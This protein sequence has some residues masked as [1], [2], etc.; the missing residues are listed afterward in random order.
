VQGHGRQGHRGIGEPGDVGPVA[1]EPAPD[2]GSA[3]HGD[4]AVRAVSAV[5]AGQAGTLASDRDGAR[6]RRAPPRQDGPGGDGGRPGRDGELQGGRGFGAGDHGPGLPVGPVEGPPP[7][8][9]HHQTVAYLD[10]YLG[11]CSAEDLGGHQAV[12]G[13]RAVGDED[14]RVGVLPG[15]G[16]EQRVGGLGGLAFPG[17]VDPGDHSQAG[18]LAVAGQAH[19]HQG[20]RWVEPQQV[21]HRRQHV[22]G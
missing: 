17:Q 8:I 18:P 22:G 6:S 1:Q 2:C 19:Q 20:P 15:D 12:V 13:G 11:Q 14:R 21:G 3:F 9:N 16:R 5:S 10:A 4:L 7:L